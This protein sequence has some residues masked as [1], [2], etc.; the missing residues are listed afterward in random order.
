MRKHTL[1]A[2]P[3]NPSWI[4]LTGTI[5]WVT[6]AIVGAAAAP[7]AVLPKATTGTHC[8]EDIYINQFFYSTT[9]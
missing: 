2:V 8:P 9:F 5:N 3:A 6:G 4:T 1:G 7:G